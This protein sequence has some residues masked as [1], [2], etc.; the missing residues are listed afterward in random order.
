MAQF[1]KDRDASQKKLDKTS[2]ELARLA[3]QQNEV[4]DKLEDLKD[5]KAKW[6]EDHILKP[7]RIRLAYAR[8]S[9]DPEKVVKGALFQGQFNEV[10]HLL[11]LR[12]TLELVEQELAARVSE[13]HN[14]IG[15][16]QKELANP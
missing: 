4:A 2:T 12:A 6:Y 3:T 1:G 9:V 5:E 15:V 14:Q 10:D 13:L 7:E 11:G 8:C 16:M